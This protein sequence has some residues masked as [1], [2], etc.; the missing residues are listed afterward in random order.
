MTLTAVQSRNIFRACIATA[1]REGETLMDDLVQFTLDELDKQAS[2]RQANAKRDLASEALALLRK[3]RGAMVKSYPQ[4][5]LEV[6]AEGPRASASR[7][8]V[9]GVNIATL[10]LVGDDEVQAQVE[11]SKAQQVVMN[12][13]E[14]VLAELNAL[15]CA[16]QGLRRIQPERN[17]LRPENYILALQ[18]V[19]S[20][21]Q[22]VAPVRQAWM[23][24][25]RGLLGK[26][27]VGAYERASQGLIKHGIQ[28]VGWSE[29]SVVHVDAGAG[30]L[31]PGGGYSGG[32][33]PGVGY[34]GGG[35]PGDGYSGGS[36]SG[37]AY[38][39]GSSPGGSYPAGGYPDAVGYPVGQY[40]SPGGG[41]PAGGY[42]GGGYPVGVPVG[43]H[44]GQ[45]GYA[46]PGGYGP[47]PP[48]A[49]GGVGGFMGPMNA[50]QNWHGPLA[51]QGQSSQVEEALLS[52]E[53]LRQLLAGGGDLYEQVYAPESPAAL[54][55][56]DAASRLDA[57]KLVQDLEDE[58]AAE[59][60]EDIAHLQRVAVQANSQS[61]DLDDGGRSGPTSLNGE[62]DPTD[63][64]E[65]V[66]SRM[67]STIANDQRLLPPIQQAVRELEPALLELVRHDNLYLRDENHPARRLLDEL[68]QRSLDFE[69]EATTGFKRFMH[70]IDQAV[71]YLSAAEITSAEPFDKVHKALVA[72]WT[73]Q[74]EKADAKR[75]AAEQASQLAGSRER[76]AE[77]VMQKI[78]ALD[79]L[80]SAPP[81]IVD[82]VLGP[83]VDAVLDY[84]PDAAGKL[85]GDALEALA[86]AEELLWSVQPAF[87]CHDLDRLDE[88]ALLLPDRIRHELERAGQ[89][90]A[91]ID[92]LLGR[93]TLLH[94]EAQLAGA[95]G[96]VRPVSSA[97]GLGA[98]G[99]GFNAQPHQIDHHVD[100]DFQ[101]Y[102]AT[103]DTQSPEF[104]RLAVPEPAA[105]IDQ[106]FKIGAW[107]ELRS[108]H[109][110]LRT[111]LTWVSP[112]NTLFMYKAP[113]GSMQSMTR[114]VRDKMLARDTLRLVE[115]QPQADAL[116]HN[117]TRAAQA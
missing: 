26:Q 63:Q 59:M 13:T 65:E 109:G 56:D 24:Q 14:E 28:Q 80:A 79:V 64:D 45:G 33:L 41:Y 27:L 86:V 12:D 25:M 111:Q 34:A 88:T 96:Y 99:A 23:S 42:P 7:R 49:G 17:P 36:Y 103:E 85:S 18:R 61:A 30:Y 97:E 108:A 81:D 87:T 102:E 9:S 62:P 113:N 100:T 83:W 93:V 68:T 77:L 74:K 76:R 11:L 44:S 106:G 37:G 19:V 3:H 40:A 29:Q 84:Q 115:T 101:P 89:P 114:R 47:Y 1:V 46:G 35:H 4:A 10:T 2:A 52:P 73:V 78:G 94:Y 31:Y 53:I 90:A 112:L 104:E 22:V 15:L 116:A 43:G 66:V 69:S 91:A 71:T 70:L 51:P 117:P 72:A 98:A 58:A 75:A 60:A 38:A 8:H 20:D 95:R 39:G 107:V 6:F 105:E 50:P 32:G 54:L 82:F 67:V 55:I 110:W 57:D 92:A 48:S 5:L 21:T 16:A